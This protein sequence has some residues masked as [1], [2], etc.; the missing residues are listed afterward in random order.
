[1]LIERNHPDLSI[2]RQCDLLGLARSSLYYAPRGES[3]ENLRRMRLIDEA[4]TRWPF[5]GVR[6]MT[7]W[8]RRQGEAVNPKRVRR[9]MRLMAWRRSIRRSA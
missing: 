9:L 3:E 2:A 6:R 4:Y 1:M 5:Y 8:L 7:A